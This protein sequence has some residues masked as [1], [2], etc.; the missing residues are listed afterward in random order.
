MPPHHLLPG[1]VLY[2]Y[3]VWVYDIHSLSL[4][5]TLSLIPMLSLKDMVLT[6]RPFIPQPFALPFPKFLL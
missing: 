2:L 4:T 5:I 6:T 3:S 1:V